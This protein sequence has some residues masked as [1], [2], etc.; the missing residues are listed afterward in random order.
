MRMSEALLLKPIRSRVFRRRMRA[1]V[2]ALAAAMRRPVGETLLRERLDALVATFDVSTIEPDPLQ[3]V[4]RYRD[5]LDQ[6]VAGLI[7]AAFAYGRADI[8]VANLGVVLSRMTPSPYRYL[9]SFDR[10]DALRRFAGF[11][12]RFHKTPEL[13]AL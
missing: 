5:P 13:V 11:A 7:A 8:I 4:L 9:A 2:S 6:E 3:L 1:R 10:R 12:H